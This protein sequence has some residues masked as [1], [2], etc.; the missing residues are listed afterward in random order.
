MAATH[1]KLDLATLLV[2]PDLHTHLPSAA[3]IVIHWYYMVPLHVQLHAY[4][5][6]KL[7]DSK[8]MAYFIAQLQ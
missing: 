6:L 2:S 4:V 5:S 7:T 1:T 3:M 8:G